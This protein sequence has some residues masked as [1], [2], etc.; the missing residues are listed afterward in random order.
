M[1]ASKWVATPSMPPNVM[2]TVITTQDDGPSFSCRKTK[3][4]T[5]RS[6][7]LGGLAGG[8]PQGQRHVMPYAS[9]PAQ[10]AWQCLHSLRRELY[11]SFPTERNLVA[12]VT[13]DKSEFCRAS[14]PGATPRRAG[15]SYGHPLQFLF[16]MH[17]TARKATAGESVGRENEPRDQSSQWLSTGPPPPCISSSPLSLCV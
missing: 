8:Q 12:R 2:T 4:H 6:Q 9:G 5:A 11:F 7:S 10:L 14:P 1:H 17:N 3:T 16:S 13:A 15:S